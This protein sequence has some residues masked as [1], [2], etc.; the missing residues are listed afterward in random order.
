M[1]IRLLLAGLASGG[2]A[3]A[4][5]SQA[6]SALADAPSADGAD[7]FTIATTTFDPYYLSSSGA[8]VQGWAPLTQISVAS[9][10]WELAE[11]VANQY[12]DVYTTNGVDIGTLSVNDYVANVLGMTN[13]GFT[14]ASATAASGDTGAQ[15]AQLPTPGTV[16]DVFNL[17]H[18]VANVY[19]A[20]PGADGTVTDTLVTP[21]G[22]L[23]LSPLVSGI[24][25]AEP[26]Q[27][28]DAFTALVG[29]TSAGNSDAFAI[30]N[31]TFDPFTVSSSGTDVPGFATVPLS[32]VTPPVLLT[33]GGTAGN[34][35]T[36]FALATQSFDVYNGTS[37]SAPDIGTITTAEDVTNLLGMTNTELVVRAPAAGGETGAQ[38]PTPGTVYDVF[39]LGHGVANVYTATPGADGTVTDTLVTPLGDLNLSPLVSGIDAAEP[40]QPADAF[41]ALVGHTSAGNSDAF[42]IGN[43]TFDPFTV[44]SSGTDVPGFAT[45]YQLLGVLP[46][47]NL[48]GGS[49]TDWIPPLATQSFDVYNG[50]SS[51]APD[52]GTLSTNEYVADLLGM[53]NTGF[54]VTGSTA[55]S[56]DTGAQAAQLPAVGTVYD[57][58]NLG[59]GVANVYIATPG[60]DG[61]VTDT[62]VTPL[63]DL[64]LSPLVS[65]IDAAM[66]NP[67]AAFDIGSAAASLIDPLAFL[68]L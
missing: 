26:L 51:S 44:S 58:F 60:A 15:A 57:V 8:E 27:P 55:A 10:L 59:H 62:L 16:Y 53:T 3:A 50:T 33:A 17:G 30:G 49:Y 2:L 46:L 41:T 37:S 19:T 66:L 56:G 40:L 42:A 63:G 24:D 65:G 32:V 21:L 43:L 38:L 14:V 22:D 36:Q 9:P 45:V 29:H 39:N 54:I 64:N 25:A 31:L 67:G 47:L 61:T 20:T 23:N 6:T 48:G 68:G 7:A 5:L 13:T 4:A 12:L 28:A 35:A 11:P 52:I 18:G 1:Y 34:P